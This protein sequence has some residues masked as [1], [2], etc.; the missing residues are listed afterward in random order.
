M[1]GKKTTP[2]AG[3]IDWEKSMTR[4][5]EIVRDLEAGKGTLDES[6]R[7]FEEGNGLVKELERALAEAELRVRKILDRGS[8][9]IR[10]EPFGEGE[11]E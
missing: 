6:L 2:E 7:L 8:E 4:L 3:R 5:E 11:E 10:E 1:S 9:G